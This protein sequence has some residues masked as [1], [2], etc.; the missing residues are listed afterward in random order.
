MATFGSRLRDLT[1]KLKNV[2]VGSIGD[3]NQ[4][5]SR[6]FAPAS[7]DARSVLYRYRESQGLDEPPQAAEVAS[8]SGLLQALR[9][10]LTAEGV[11]D[12]IGFE[13]G[14]LRERLEV[15]QSILNDP[16]IFQKALDSELK[17]RRDVSRK[18]I[19]QGIKDGKITLEELGVN[20]DFGSVDDAPILRDYVLDKQSEAEIIHRVAKDV[21]RQMKEQSVLKKLGYN[22]GAIAGDI[23]E[24]RSRSLY[25]LLNAPQA[26]TATTADLLMSGTS[27]N[28]RSMRSIGRQDLKRAEQAGL[29]RKVGN[30]PLSRSQIDSIQ[31]NNPDFFMNPGNAEQESIYLNLDNFEPAQPGIRRKY[32]KR[33][34]NIL[35]SGDGKPGDTV[36]GQRRISPST[37]AAAGLGGTALATNAGLG[38]TGTEET[39]IPFVG[40][41]EGYAAAS[42]DELD[43]RQ[44]NNAAFEIGTRYLLS[45]DGRMLPK[46]DFLLERPDVTAGEFADY[47]AYMH[48]KDL[49][50]N[51][52]D[53]GKTN[54]GIVKTNADGIHGG[55]VQILGQTLS[56]NEAGIPLL[57]AM[58]GMAAGAVLP[59]L[60]QIRLLNQRSSWRPGVGRRGMIKNIMGYLPEV[61]A[62]RYDRKLDTNPNN[63]LLKNKTIDKATQAVEDFFLETNPVTQ[64][65]D[66]NRG[67][68]VGALAAGTF[69]GVGLG[70]AIGLERED[71]R[72]RE[73][74]AE[75]NPGIDYD[76]YKQ[77]ARN[78]L[79]QKYALMASDPDRT[80]KQEKS[81]SGFSRTA[82]KE[83]LMNYMQ[84][85]QAAIDTVANAYLKSKGM[86]SLAKQQW[87]LDKINELEEE[88]NKTNTLPL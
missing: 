76:V 29:L 41:R 30:E 44:S 28:L 12:P 27:P 6:G 64:Q 26:V 15:G 69:G 54:L 81:K 77:N 42:P 7:E 17:K 32:D 36:F 63:P 45:R 85:Q 22:L 65:L 23:N 70:T 67:R 50:F 61:R 59:N 60:R 24:D 48:G 87:A 56:N 40:R 9:D 72:R 80:E 46:A 57:G 43:P 88:E 19:E 84:E 73:N 11:P 1:E 10:G 13:D 20:P 71:R 18:E 21:K 75:I 35:R 79:D 2:N 83:S 16:T 3:L 55:E 4:G 14:M 8:R 37:L 33:A 62:K 86:E 82:Q 74:F 66:M 53:D 58:G 49:D 52:F 51:P 25:W 38:L 78:L 34:E 31:R 5:F 39:G 68:V 47:Q